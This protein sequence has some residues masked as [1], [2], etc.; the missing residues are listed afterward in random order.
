MDSENCRNALTPKN[1]EKIIWNVCICAHINQLASITTGLTAAPVDSIFWR[2]K[3]E[4]RHSCN[5]QSSGKINIDCQ[6]HILPNC[7]SRKQQ[8]LNVVTKWD[9][10]SPF[11]SHINGYGERIFSFVSKRVVTNFDTSRS[12]LMGSC[13][14]QSR[15]INLYFPCTQHITSIRPDANVISLGNAQTAGSTYASWVFTITIPQALFIYK[16]FIWFQHFSVFYKQYVTCALIA[17]VVWWLTC[18]KTSW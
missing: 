14:T 12:T 8:I 10:N 16:S 1:W 5:F 11:K 9:L 7:L 2:D 3:P 17:K 13:N 4:W 18:G 15:N 6:N